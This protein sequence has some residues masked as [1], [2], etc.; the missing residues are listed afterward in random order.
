[1]LRPNFDSF[2]CL[3]DPGDSNTVHTLQ[4]TKFAFDVNSHNAVHASHATQ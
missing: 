2:N 4:L 1:V 3:T